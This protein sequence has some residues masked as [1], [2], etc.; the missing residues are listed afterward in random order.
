[1][2]VRRG[3]RLRRGARRARLPLAPDPAPDRDPT[4][5][6]GRLPADAGRLHGQQRAARARRRDPAH[7]AAREPY[8]G[9]PPRDPLV[10]GGG[11]AARRRR[12]RRAV[13]GAHLGGRRPPARGADAGHG[14]RDRARA[15]GDRLRRLPGAAPSRLLPRVPREGRPVPAR[16][17]ALCARRGRVAGGPDRLGVVLRGADAAADRD[18]ARA[19]AAH[20]RHAAD[21][22]ARLAVRRHPCGAGLRGHVRRRDRARA[23]GGRGDGRRGGRLRPARAFR[24]VRPGDARRALPAAA[25]LRRLPPRAGRLRGSRRCGE[26]R[27]G[28]PTSRARTRRRRWRPG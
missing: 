1:M 18:V 9:A 28:T 17:A 2:A 4:R 5:A 19:R 7:R 25:H 8:D 6:R 16:A 15:R 21:H 20:P 26:P 11:A 27:G 14:R 12:A 10:G 22:R 3:L 13:R 23:Q 24:D